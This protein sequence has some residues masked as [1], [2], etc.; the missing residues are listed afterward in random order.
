LLGRKVKLELFVRVT[1][2]WKETPRM[3]AELG[4]EPTGEK[5]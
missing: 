3:L 2:R 4:Y 1:P 5:K